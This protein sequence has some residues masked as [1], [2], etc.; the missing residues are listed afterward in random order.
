METTFQGFAGADYDLQVEF[1][2]LHLPPH[3][4]AWRTIVLN[5][6]QHSGSACLPQRDCC[7]TGGY[8]DGTFDSAFL[9]TRA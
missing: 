1:R 8:S 9:L 5:Y 6:Q 3:L 7:L 4:R 2:Q